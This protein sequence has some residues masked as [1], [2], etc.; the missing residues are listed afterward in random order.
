MKPIQTGN[1]ENRSEHSSTIAGLAE[2][3]LSSL[4]R[5][6][7]R[8]FRPSIVS[9]DIMGPKRKVSSLQAVT[10]VASTSAA[11]DLPA[12]SQISIS[13]QAQM[14]TGR[15]PRKASTVASQL[16][17][18]SSAAVKLPEDNDGDMSDLTPVQSE[19]E[20]ASNHSEDTPLTE[21][22]ASEPEQ[23]PAK[24]KA[25]KV[26]PR[27]AKSATA[28]ITA[29]AD[30]AHAEAAEGDAVNESS[31]KKKAKTPRKP[32]P[33]KPDPVYVIPDVEKKTTTFKGYVFSLL[34]NRLSRLIGFC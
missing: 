11:I 22:D 16:I 9:I 19:A 14:E 25:K 31:K 8:S 34:S 32:R 6:A 18:E 28:P 26:T 30:D 3:C 20:D 23:K 15:T 4:A 17:Q 24:K 1:F 7:R 27:K 21:P 12:L 10:P 2:R 5:V 29:A 33:P 13:Y